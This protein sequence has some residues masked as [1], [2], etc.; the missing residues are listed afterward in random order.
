ME[1]YRDLDGSGHYAEGEPYQDCNANGRW[2][3]NFIGGGGGGTRYYTKEADPVTSRAIVV[4]NGSRTIAVEVTDQEG[5]FN[6][7]QAQ[8]RAKV[9]A[10]MGGAKSPLKDGDMF[11]S[12]THDESA[13]QTLG[14][15]GASDVTSATNDYF[16]TYFIDQ[17][18]KAIEQAYGNRR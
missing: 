14:L 2:D 16:L 7:Y 15:N 9:I 6:V 13:P 12:A 18:A 3:G 4:S 10:D 11:L 5:L 1:P 17:S 8:I